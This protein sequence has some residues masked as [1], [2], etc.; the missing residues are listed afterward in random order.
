MNTFNEYGPSALLLLASL[1]FLGAVIY[2]FHHER[3]TR[4]K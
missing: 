3:K 1:A 2:F 4:P